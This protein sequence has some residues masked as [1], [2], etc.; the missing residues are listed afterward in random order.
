MYFLLFLIYF[1]LYFIN[2]DTYLNENFISV[3]NKELS[4]YITLLLM[5]TGCNVSMTT[6]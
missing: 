3:M 1:C 2:V 5:L 6:S 4:F